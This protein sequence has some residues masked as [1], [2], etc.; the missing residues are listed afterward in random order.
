V[1]D[2]ASDTFDESKEEIDRMPISV[3]RR[4]YVAGWAGTVLTL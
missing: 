4:P 1:A 2:K 3:E